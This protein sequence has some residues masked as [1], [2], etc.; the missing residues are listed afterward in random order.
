MNPN[1]EEFIFPQ[2]T[3]ANT[4]ATG[5]GDGNNAA[6]EAAAETPEGM[7]EYVDFL[8]KVNTVG[9]ISEKLAAYSHPAQISHK[10]MAEYY[11]ALEIHIIPFLGKYGYEELKRAVEESYNSFVDQV[12]GRINN[13]ARGNEVV[14]QA[15]F[16]PLAVID[17]ALKDAIEEKRRKTLPSFT[18]W[19]GCLWNQHLAT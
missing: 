15:Y 16:D 12:S 10:E 14:S 17:R 2:A 19:Q 4:S 5:A 1:V 8:E 18:N 13:P 7:V 11:G 9:V 6:A 3:D